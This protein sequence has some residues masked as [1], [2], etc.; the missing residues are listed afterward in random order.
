M[1]DYEHRNA[2]R[3]AFGQQNKDE[4]SEYSLRLSCYANKAMQAF[5]ATAGD[6]LQPGDLIRCLLHWRDHN[7]FTATGS[8]NAAKMEY[9]FDRGRGFSGMG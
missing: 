7:G 9:G 5:R 2:I 3:T 1:D 8:V 6:T 4:H